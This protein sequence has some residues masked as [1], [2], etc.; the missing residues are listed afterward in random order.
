MALP[1]ASAQ[2]VC[3]QIMFA[4]NHAVDPSVVDSREVREIVIEENVEAV[5]VVKT[6][7]HVEL[8]FDSMI[9]DV[10]ER[11]GVVYTRQQAR[12]VESVVVKEE[13]TQEIDE[14]FQTPDE[15]VDVLR[16]AG[17]N[18]AEINAKHASRL[19]MES[20]EHLIKELKYGETQED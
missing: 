2:I 16:A 11:D 3:L 6:K 20:L 5:I 10:F 17:G 19:E 14:G 12:V 18:F 8:I 9:I 1:W 4:P 13:E 7:F 15:P